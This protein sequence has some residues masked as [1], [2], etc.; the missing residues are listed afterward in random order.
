MKIKSF[1]P[2][3]LKARGLAFLLLLSLLNA[4]KATAETFNMADV[5]G[6]TLS[7]DCIDYCVVGICV[8]LICTPVGC[9]LDYSPRVEHNIPDLVVSVY[10]GVDEQPW[11]EYQPIQNALLSSVGNNGAGL[12]Q[13]EKISSSP[14]IFK[15]S[16]A[17]GH[18]LLLLFGNLNFE[19]PPG[20][21]YS[22]SS[23]GDLSNDCVFNNNI[24][25]ACP[26]VDE[27]EISWSSN[28]EEDAAAIE[29]AQDTLEEVSSDESFKGFCRSKTT[30]F[31]PYYESTID[32]FEWRFGVIDRFKAIQNGAH[33]P[34][35]REIGSLNSLNPIGKNT[36]GAVY[37]R[38]GFVLQTEDPK[39][40]AVIAQRTVDIVTRNDSWRMNLNAPGAESNEKTDKWQMISPKGEDI[41]RPFGSSDSD[42][43]EGRN[44][45][46][47]GQYG[48]NYWRRYSCCPF[49][50]GILIA[51]IPT[52]PIC[53][54]DM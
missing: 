19:L 6:S 40:A 53:I 27:L 52:P 51:V 5:L 26:E 9:S 14:V 45:D 32:L 10:D 18:P 44:P 12:M 11:E 47:K 48:W 23:D 46:G 1:K 34:G 25:V 15:N 29:E 4:P 43:S 50:V 20:Y 17:I 3:S 33:I 36:W 49:G 54:N 13:G 38:I 31:I 22:F 8:H 37:P 41:C 28:E 16:S 39:A 24:F 21:S 2:L 42:W 30:P 7:L 35:N